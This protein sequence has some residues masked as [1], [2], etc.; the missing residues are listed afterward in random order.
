MIEDGEMGSVRAVVALVMALEV[1]LVMALVVALVMALEDIG[2]GKFGKIKKGIEG[3]LGRV[4]SSI[5]RVAKNI[6]LS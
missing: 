4:L 1:A 3:S 6:S 2:E 5:R